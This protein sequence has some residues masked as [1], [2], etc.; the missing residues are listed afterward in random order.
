MDFRYKSC[1]MHLPS[2]CYSSY[3]YILWGLRDWNHKYLPGSQ[4]HHKCFISKSRPEKWVTEMFF[5]LNISGKMLIENCIT[6]IEWNWFWNVN[7]YFN[8]VSDKVLSKYHLKVYIA[9]STRIVRNKPGQNP[10]KVSAIINLSTL[11]YLC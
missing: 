3:L 8:D 11:D 10:G 2:N 1:F 9:F 4:K 6:S 5:S 7:S